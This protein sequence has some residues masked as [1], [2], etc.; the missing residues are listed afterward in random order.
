[1]MTPRTGKRITAI[2]LAAT[3]TFALAGCGHADVTDGPSMA[4]DGDGLTECT[5][6]MRDGRRVQ[7]IVR[8]SSPSRSGIS[9]DWAHADGADNQDEGRQ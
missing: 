1:M 2:I 9:C 7:C 6:T 3:L 8:D 5:V 4:C